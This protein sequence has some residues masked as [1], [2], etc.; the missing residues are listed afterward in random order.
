MVMFASLLASAAAANAIATSAP[1]ATPAPNRAVTERVVAAR[2]PITTRDIVEVAEISAPTLSPDGLRIAY[3]VSHPSVEANSSRLSWQIVDVG[4]SGTVVTL[5][6][7]TERPDASGVPVETAPLWDSDS[8]G[9]RFLAL[10]DGITAVWHWRDGAPLTREIVDDADILDFGPAADGKSVRYTI[11]ATRDAIAAA[12]RSAYRDGV[13][14][15]G[16]VNLNQPVAG[17]VIEDG[18]RII[19]RIAS[20]WFDNQRI[21]WDTPR[22][23]KS[24]IPDVAAHLPAPPGPAQG[25]SSRAPDGRLA[26]ISGE[27]AAQ[28]LRVTHPNGRAILCNAAPCQSGRLNALAWRPGKNALLLFERDRSAR[29]IIWSWTV[30]ARTARKLAET[31]GALRVPG[32]PPR[33]AVGK[34][35]LYCA[36]AQPLHPPR[37][38]RIDL[39]SGKNHILAQPNRALDTRI[40]AKVAPMA[41]AGGFTGYFLTPADAGGPFPVVVQYYM[42]DGFLKG[43]TGDEIPMLPLIEHGIAVL[44]IDA[45]RAPRSSGMEGSYNLALQTIG[46]ALD[47]LA[48][49]GKIDP[50]RVGIGG[51]SFGSSVALWS[52]RKS[53]R[54][55]AATVASGQI[56]PH[57]YWMNALPDR[58]FT[59]V[60]EDYWQ[61]GPPDNAP[62]RWRLITPLWDI[63]ALSTPLLMQVPESEVQSNVE[64]HTRLKLAGKP[65]EMVVFADE[66][67]IKYQPAH[68]RA[69]YERNLD[70]YR[71]WL[72][73][74]EDVALAKTDQYRRWRALRAGQSLPVPAR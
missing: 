39:T 52:I 12:E 71:F 42:C 1:A 66:L 20:P 57:Y 21:L 58:G 56:S 19:R 38:V 5:D 36:D 72:K 33:C 35:S 2:T 17:G 62:D 31:S 25:L 16:S 11:G 59:A 74:E 23:D 70:W 26:E 10:R 24:F 41:W 13:V 55:A 44:C 15:D 6:G 29:E 68:K 7:G 54:F 43:G 47:G 9:L 8:R 4:G 61:L 14:V 63:D 60:L 46:S 45:V 64:L 37:L 48:A 65:A 30:G 27:K 73:G 28:R 18:R 22:T 51:L 3:R 50:A 49:D 32:R 53:T 40:A 67:H 69:S 34:D